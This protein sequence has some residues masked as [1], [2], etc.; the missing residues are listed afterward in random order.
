MRT[1]LICGFAVSLLFASCKDPVGAEQDKGS[2][3]NKDYQEPSPSTT[4]A[5]GSGDTVG[6]KAKETGTTTGEYNSDGYNKTTKDKTVPPG[7]GS[8]T[9]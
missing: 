9:Y 6:T 8:T 3:Y 2:G 7:K 4:A 5:A 1:L